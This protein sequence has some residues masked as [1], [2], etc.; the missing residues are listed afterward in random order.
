MPVPPRGNEVREEVEEKQ[1][2]KSWGPCFLEQS[3]KTHCQTDKIFARLSEDSN[4]QG[5]GVF[6]FPLLVFPPRVCDKDISCFWGCERKRG[7]GKEG[8]NR[9][10]HRQDTSE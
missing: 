5:H 6:R 10:Q 1:T 9:G 7:T 3:D 4:S 8:G 2:V